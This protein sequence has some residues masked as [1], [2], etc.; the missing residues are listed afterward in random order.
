MIL[1]VDDRDDFANMVRGGISQENSLQGNAWTFQHVNPDMRFQSGIDVMNP[2]FSEVMKKI[3]LE[4][5]II[6]LDA[7]FLSPLAYELGDPQIVQDILDRAHS[8]HI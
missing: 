3:Q 5:V 7:S 4:R 6:L 1:L 8:L 2:S